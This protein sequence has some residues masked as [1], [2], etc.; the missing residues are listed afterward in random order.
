M[1]QTQHV[2]DTKECVDCRTVLLVGAPLCG[3]CGG[4][5]FRLRNQSRF[6]YDAIAAFIGVVVVILFWVVRG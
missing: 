5:D 3:A 6:P 2:D 4:R 1:Q